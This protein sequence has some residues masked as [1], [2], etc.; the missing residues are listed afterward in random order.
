[1][2]QEPVKPG[3]K[4]KPTQNQDE[5]LMDDFEFKPITSG[6]GFHQPKQTEIKPVYT[7]RIPSVQSTPAPGPSPKKNEN[8]YQN[9][10]S[11]F[12]GH[13][14]N[15]PATSTAPAQTPPEEVAE[16][17]YRLATK[18]QRVFA[19]LT[20][21]ALICSILGL[22]LT[23]MARTISMDLLAVWEQYPAE[24]TP[25]VITLFCGFYLMYFSIF[26]KASQSTLGKNLFNLRVLG[27]NDKPLSLS[28]LL[29]RSFVS[30]LNFVSLGL[31]SY[32]DLQSKVT[33]SKVIRVD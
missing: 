17:S 32:F 18:S 29:L 5:F 23:V 12:Y 25:L 28:T 9:D 26:E 10:L 7:E 13:A 21:L 22:V 8:V 6:L 30:L 27:T 31:F 1:M 2:N 24:I 16:K 19:Y 15:H 33:S 20:D 14:Q 11:L 4:T 3:Q